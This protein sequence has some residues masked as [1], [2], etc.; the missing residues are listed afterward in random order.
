MYYVYILKNKITKKYYTGY[1]SDIAK[2]LKEHNSGKT[3][4]LRN[5]GKYELVYKEEYE[6][7]SAAY[8][9][10][11]EIKSYKGGEAFKRLIGS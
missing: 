3:K 1:T 4:S 10:E 8:R 9:R 5:R 11:R 7:R 2:R 6:T